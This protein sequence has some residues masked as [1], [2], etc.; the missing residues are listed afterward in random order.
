MY[1]A[2]SIETRT[3]RDRQSSQQYRFDLDTPPNKNGTAKMAVQVFDEGAIP[4]SGDHFFACHPVEFTGDVVEGGAFTATADAN[5]TLYV[6]FIGSQTPS[7]DD[8]AV[9]SLI[10]GRW[11]AERGGATPDCSVIKCLPCPLPAKDLQLAWTNVITGDG[12]ITLAFDG[13]AWQSVCSNGVI[14]SYSCELGF[15]IFYYSGKDCLSGDQ[16]T[17]SAPGDAPFKLDVGDS[18]CKPLSL[19]FSSDIDDCPG[20][21]AMGYTDFIV[22]DPSP[23]PPGACSVC[24]N[25]LGCIGAPVVGATVTI[26]S[27]GTTVATGKTST[28]GVVVLDVGKTGPYTVVV[29]SPRFATSTQVLTLVCG[30]AIT[31]TLGPDADH[32]C[33]FPDC[34]LPVSK[35]LF[36]TAKTNSDCNGT[37]GPI[38]MTWNGTAWAFSDPSPLVLVNGLLLNCQ[39]LL[40]ITQSFCGGGGCEFGQLPL[41][42]TCPPTFAFNYAGDFGGDFLSCCLFCSV[43]V[44]E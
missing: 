38:P 21:T 30:K 19:E 27:G 11:V 8:I 34:N 22:T 36:W 37:L 43:M 29:T 42:R 26:S 33:C 1:E 4:A 32:V 18:T 16:K 44:T 39:G 15:A 6:D 31:V 40:Q 28:T 2:Y 23:K 25:V 14:Y 7:V 13:A 20:V 3:L 5:T 12:T 10:G 41:S 17:C 9:A 35:T 24:I